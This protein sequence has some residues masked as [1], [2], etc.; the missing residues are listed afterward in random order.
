VID[1]AGPPVTPEPPPPEVLA[2]IEFERRPENLISASEDVVRYH[3]LVRA[4]RESFPPV[5]P[6]KLRPVPRSWRASGAGGGFR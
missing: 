3:P 6:R 1:G 4:A 2:Q 5:G